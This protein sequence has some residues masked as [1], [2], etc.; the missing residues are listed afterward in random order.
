MTLCRSHCA[1]K[2]L[3]HANIST[4]TATKPS[5]GFVLKDIKS[6]ILQIPSHPRVLIKNVTWPANFCRELHPVLFSTWKKKGE[7]VGD[8]M[9]SWEQESCTAEMWCVPQPHFR[10][11]SP[12]SFRRGGQRWAGTSPQS[13]VPRG[14]KAVPSWSSARGAAASGAHQLLTLLVQLQ[15]SA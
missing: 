6:H 11:L 14:R 9:I 7:G 15:W 1:G 10:R 5:S 2:A 4:K 3:K 13:P 12:T 8:D